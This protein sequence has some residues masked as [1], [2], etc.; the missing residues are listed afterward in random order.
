MNMLIDE[1]KKA[2]ISAMKE[3]DRIG[4]N[5]FSLVINK[6][7]MASIELRKQNKELNDADDVSLIQKSIKELEEEK[8][9]YIANNRNE[10]AQETQHQIDVLKIYLPKMMS[11]EEI[12]EII[13]KLEDK[14][15]K[16]VMVTFKTNYAGKVDMSLVS[17]VVRD[18]QK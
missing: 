4:A 12:R 9:M 8:A 17:K 10:S 1:L 13:S 11:E 6:H 3:R 15:M 2:K 5:A 14:S 7:L 18:I 16:N